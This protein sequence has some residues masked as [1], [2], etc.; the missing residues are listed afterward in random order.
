MP[1]AVRAGNPQIPWRWVIVTRNF[2]I[3]GY[4]GIDYD[5]LWSIVRDDAPDLLD[6]L[7][8]LKTKL[9]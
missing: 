9:G 7:T 5:I 6:K 3:H 2:L 1:E 4:L 8:E